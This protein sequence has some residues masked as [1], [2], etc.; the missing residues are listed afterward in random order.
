M[1]GT[2]SS[3]LSASKHAA[4]TL[5]LQKSQSL[6]L[7]PV[8]PTLSMAGALPASKPVSWLQLGERQCLPPESMCPISWIEH[9]METDFVCHSSTEQLSGAGDLC[10]FSCPH[11]AIVLSFLVPGAVDS[12][13]HTNTHTFSCTQVYNHMCCASTCMYS[14]CKFILI[15]TYPT[16]TQVHTLTQP[17]L[18]LPHK[19][20]CTAPLHT[21]HPQCTHK[22]T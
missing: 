6:P 12:V 5:P 22:H 11:N 21:H 1:T 13:T 7:R 10:H 4:G 16:G 19:P 8:P 9:I 17:S 3:C 15:H 14:T 20:V 18:L 2:L